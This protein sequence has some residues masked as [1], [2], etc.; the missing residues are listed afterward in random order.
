MNNHS[1]TDVGK[2]ANG[3]ILTLRA[4]K[5][6]ALTIFRAYQE[7]DLSNYSSCLSLLLELTKFVTPLLPLNLAVHLSLYFV[8]LQ[9]TLHFLAR[10]IIQIAN[11]ESEKTC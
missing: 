3:K 2:G 5:F 1:L 9:V 11:T 6:S 8:Q 7:A 4:I 10:T